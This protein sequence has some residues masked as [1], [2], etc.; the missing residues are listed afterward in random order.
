MPN[1]HFCLAA[2][3]FSYRRTES[4][5]LRCSVWSDSDEL[6]I[7]ISSK[8]TTTNRPMNGCKAWFIILMKVLG[9][10]ERPKGITSHS[11]SIYLVL[12]A[13]LH[14][15]PGRIRI[16]WY[17]FLRSIFEFFLAEPIWSKRSSKRGI[18][19]RYLTV[20]LLIARLSTH[21]RQDPSFFEIRRAGT[22]QGLRLSSMWPLRRRSS[23]WRHNSPCSNGL[24]R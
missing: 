6:K 11:K 17:L 5:L 3:N 21:M 18:G 15:S 2:N 4:T 7:S 12:K 9:V 16:W 24:I 20:I 8:Y 22:A 10:L 1:S 19:N 23:T 14:S 13:V